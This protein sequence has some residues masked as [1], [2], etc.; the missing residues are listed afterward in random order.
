MEKRPKFAWT[1]VP[2]TPEKTAPKGRMGRKELGEIL[3]AR[4][5]DVTRVADLKVLANLY[6]ELRRWKEP[7][8][9]RGR[10]NDPQHALANL[11]KKQEKENGLVDLERQEKAE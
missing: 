11:E 7:A 5:R 6:M 8:K 1:P 2:E 3:S 4:L 10:T 9:P